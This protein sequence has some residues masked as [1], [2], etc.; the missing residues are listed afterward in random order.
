MSQ[1]V[2]KGLVYRETS[3]ACACEAIDVAEDF[4]IGVP[5]VIIELAAAAQ[6]ECEKK[7]SPPG[8]KLPVIL[9][10][11]LVSGIG[12]GVKLPVKSRPEVTNGLDECFSQP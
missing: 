3:L 12:Q 2:N 1:E 7:Q 9:Y 11:G 6:L 10:K 4:Q 5:E 8:E